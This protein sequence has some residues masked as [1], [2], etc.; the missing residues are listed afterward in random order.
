MGPEGPI[1]P[2]GALAPNSLTGWTVVSKKLTVTPTQGFAKTVFL[3]VNCPA[4]KDA[5]GGGANGEFL[6][7]SS[8]PQYSTTT[9]GWSARWRI[10]TDWNGQ[11]NASSFD[12][13]V[14]VI[15]AYT[16]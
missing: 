8:F 4:G 10:P 9:G 15:C 12:Y 5:I 1:G 16:R 2:Q 11:V 14:Y 13:T 3:T 6:L 7:G